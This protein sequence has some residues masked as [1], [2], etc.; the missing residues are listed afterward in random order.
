[1]KRIDVLSYLEEHSGDFEVDDA[2]IESASDGSF[3]NSNLFMQR[4]NTMGESSSVLRRH[5]ASMQGLGRSI[6]SVS[7]SEASSD[8]GDY[9]DFDF[10]LKKNSI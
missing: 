10:F 5:S 4:F 6:S 7:S 2:A 1:M 3:G 9:F 8:A